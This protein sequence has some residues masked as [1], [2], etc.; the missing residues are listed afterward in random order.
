V[1]HQ[2]EVWLGVGAGGQGMN[3]QTIQATQANVLN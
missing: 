2:R 3:A 1:T